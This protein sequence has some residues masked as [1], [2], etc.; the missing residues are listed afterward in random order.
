M[1]P[2][3]KSSPKDDSKD[4]SDLW[5]RV[6]AQDDLIYKALHSLHTKQLDI[7]E[8]LSTIM[9]N[10]QEYY[11]NMMGIKQHGQRLS[12]NDFAHI[13]DDPKDDTE[14]DDDKNNNYQ[15]AQP[16]DAL[17]KKKGRGRPPKQ[18]QGNQN[19]LKSPSKT[20]TLTPQKRGRPPKLANKL[21][22]KV[23]I[24]KEP[25]APPSHGDPPDSPCHNYSIILSADDDDD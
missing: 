11:C 18:K 16:K 14:D 19:V 8:K 3:K 1:P 21:N 12:M 5:S 24:R 13:Q 20:P 7:D 23:K 2:K 25:P 4:D 9:T 15:D 17:T 6:H 22:N 10:Y